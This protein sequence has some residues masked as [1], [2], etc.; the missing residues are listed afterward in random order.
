[1]HQSQPLWSGHV[2]KH[3][4]NCASMPRDVRENLGLAQVPAWRLNALFGAG[5][6]DGYAYGDGSQ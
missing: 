6:L 1:M 4:G 5:K 2:Q 3:G